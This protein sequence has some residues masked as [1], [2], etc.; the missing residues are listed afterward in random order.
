VLNK[1]VV[2]RGVVFSSFS[3]HT[4]SSF[5]LILHTHNLILIASLF[6]VINNKLNLSVHFIL[7]LFLYFY[8]FVLRFFSTAEETTPYGNKSKHQTTWHT[9]FE[10]MLHFNFNSFTLKY[11]VGMCIHMQRCQVF[12][13]KWRQGN[14]L[15]W[16]SQQ[17]QTGFKSFKLA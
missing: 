4:T 15:K 3:K 9:F 7:F 13:E 11:F 6:V 17:F 2:K 10:Y 1:F 5:W 12:Q 8:S 16:C 14:F